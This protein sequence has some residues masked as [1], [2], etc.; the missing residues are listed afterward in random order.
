MTEWQAY[1]TIEPVGDLAA[2]IRLAKLGALVA[3]IARA[4]WSKKGTYKPVSPQEF[5]PDWTMPKT[6]TDKPQQ[7]VEDMKRVLMAM[8]DRQNKY[9]ARRDALKRTN[10]PVS[11]RT[12]NRVKPPGRKVKGDG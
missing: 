10:P 12:A 2:E 5:L 9:I 1:A 7:S 6:T 3:N 8:A 11:K 4:A